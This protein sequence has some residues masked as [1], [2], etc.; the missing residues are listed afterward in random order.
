MREVVV[1]FVDL[2]GAV[3]RV[4]EQRGGLRGLGGRLGLEDRRESPLF[5][6][7]ARARAHE[8]ARARVRA[9]AHAVL[10]QNRVPLRELFVRRACATR[11]EEILSRRWETSLRTVWT[12]IRESART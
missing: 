7:R 9:R 2:V 5:V 12:H 1:E 10:D 8:A 11:G 3:E 6:A 4:L